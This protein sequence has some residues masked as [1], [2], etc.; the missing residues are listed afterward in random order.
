[1]IKRRYYSDLIKLP[2]LKERYD[3]LRIGGKV[4]QST[5]GYDRW[6]N[7]MFYALPEWKSVRNKIIIRDNGCLF[8]LEG[9]EIK[10]GIVIHHMNPITRE[11][12]VDRNPDIFN[13]EFLICVDDRV[14]KAIHYGNENL[15]PQDPI[16]R[17]PFDT[18]PWKH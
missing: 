6:L 11:D 9:Y 12:I 1:M 17:R 15:L 2:T 7:Q 14:H 8:G 3:Y 5:F 16:E 4:G 10:S 18:C 13:P